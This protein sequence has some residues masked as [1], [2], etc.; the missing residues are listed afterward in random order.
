MACDLDL[1]CV[2]DIYLTFALILDRF[3]RRVG[4]SCYPDYC[5]IDISYNKNF[6]KLCVIDLYLGHDLFQ[7]DRALV[8][9][10]VIAMVGDLDLRSLVLDRKEVTE[11]FIY[12]SLFI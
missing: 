9:T 11:Y 12:M 2:L 6:Y 3:S 8:V 4:F 5:D 1:C 10:P 7:Q